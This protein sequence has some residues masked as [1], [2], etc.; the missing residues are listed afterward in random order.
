M[1]WWSDW[2]S[3]CMWSLSLSFNPQTHK[4]SALSS[5][6]KNM[7]LFLF[8]I[9]ILAHIK[10]IWKPNCKEWDWNNHTQLSIQIS[11]SLWLCLAKLTN[12]KE[13]IQEIGIIG[14]ISTFVWL[15]LIMFKV[16]LVKWNCVYMLSLGLG[17][18]IKP[19]GSWKFCIYLRSWKQQ[20]SHADKLSTFCDLKNFMRHTC[21]EASVFSSWD[22]TWNS[23]HFR[24]SLS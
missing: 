12:W 17:I 6:W 2:W 16:I 8:Q 23:Y 13:L 20:T 5:S 1:D 22:R 3:L 9:Q 14:P 15:N 24:Q 7:Y 4:L 18:K 21:L 10:R 19:F 11:S